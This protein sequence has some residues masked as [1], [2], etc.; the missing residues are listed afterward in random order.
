MVRKLGTW[1]LAPGR[2]DGYLSDV[3]SPRS[4][5]GS[6]FPRSSSALDVLPI[7]LPTS[8]L[9]TAWLRPGLIRGV[10]SHT[11]TQSQHTPHPAGVGLERKTA[12]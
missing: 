2:G 3:A 5:G 8:R 6:G 7:R 11:I 12:T 9:A 1:H 4:G 10:T